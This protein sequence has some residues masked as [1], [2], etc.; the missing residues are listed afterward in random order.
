VKAEPAAPG[1][2]SGATGEAPRPPTASTAAAPTQPTPTEAQRFGPALAGARP[3]GPTP[4]AALLAQI[5]RLTL[6]AR[7]A[8]Q[9]AV[10][11]MH[12][13]TRR[14]TSIAFSEHK[15]YAPGD[16]VRHLDWHAFAK[17]DR[18]HIKQYEDEN[19]L[20]LQLW[21]DHSGSMGFQHGTRPTKLA[22]ATY[23]AAAL[24]H[25]ALGQ[26]DAVG[27]A[28]FAAGISS[29]LPARAQVS[30][31]NE[32]L[33]RL[34]QLLPGGATG[35]SQAVQSLGARTARRQV[36]MVMTDLFDPDPNLLGAFQQLTARRNEVTLLHILDPAEISFDYELPTTFAS[37]E[38][39][40]QLFVHPRTLRKTYIAEMEKFLAQTQ[41]DMAAAGIS[42]HLARTDLDEA[43]VLR[44]CLQ[45][46]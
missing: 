1:H 26:G 40:R 24:A 28:T 7:F 44:H 30:H 37:M 5:E 46:V 19:N 23:L 18:Y 34:T 21:V 35:V 39:A 43:T 11:G 41:R 10:A 22:Y 17:T 42:Y 29:E 6:K 20:T 45:N 9:G 13:A 25:I 4:D 12:R 32:L 38:D 3:Q 8:A 33:T 16:D 31:Y 27:L 2:L 15:L 36:I 14:G